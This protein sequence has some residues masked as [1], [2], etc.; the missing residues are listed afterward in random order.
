MNLSSN[1]SSEEIRAAYRSLIKQY[2]PDKNS[3]EQASEFTLKLNEAYD[4]LSDPEKKS[5]YDNR[6]YQAPAEE[7]IYEEDPREV[8]RREY[9]R[10]KAETV[11]EAQ[12]TEVRRQ[13][14]QFRLGRLLS[15]PI[16]AFALLVIMDRY[17][18][19]HISTDIPI[20]GWQVGSGGGRHGS[21]R[22]YTSF[23]KSDH[24]T[25]EVPNA[26]HI[27]YD[28][29]AA[30]KEPIIIMATPILRTIKSYAVCNGN[31]KTIYPVLGTP[32]LP[33]L[34][35]ISAAF[36]ASRR[37]FSYTAYVFRFLPPLLL[38][39]ELVFYIF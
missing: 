4:V 27:N 39:A 25:Y 13:H 33:L 7:T 34:I 22:T 12:E 24:A 38:A 30:E 15:F 23:M 18:P 8:Y 26:L 36:I 29:Y 21:T 28:Y 10:Q 14:T 19:A 37:K 11:R 32:L 2:H 6:F 35:L 5:Q 16:L 3:S 17:L 31:I 1:A 20:V 9:I